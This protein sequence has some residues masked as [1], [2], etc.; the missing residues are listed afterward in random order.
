MRCALIDN[1]TLTAVQRIL[2][3]ISVK[4]KHTIDGDIIALENYIQSILFYDKVVYLNDYKE[5]YRKS[6]EK[7]FYN[8]IK[9]EPSEIG[10]NSLIQATKKVTDGIIPCVEGGK[11]T[12]SDFKPFFELLKMNVT[13]TWDM[14][15]SVYFLTE[16]M[17]EQVGGLDIS[18]YS[19]LSSMIF[20]ELSEK[21][22]LKK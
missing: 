5:G 19:K 1:A 2:G 14:R 3:D 16:K 15:S 4:N 9:F 13:F 18:K 22:S 10:Y 21:N 11:F 17:L 7:F 6:R 20:M 12:D 8:M